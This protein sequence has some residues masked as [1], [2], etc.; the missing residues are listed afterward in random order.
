MVANFVSD[1]AQDATVRSL[2]EVSV[3]ETMAVYLSLLEKAPD[4]ADVAALALREHGRAGRLEASHIQMLGAFV[5]GAPNPLCA[6]HL[7]KALAAMGREATEASEPLIAKMRPMMITDDVEYW[8]FD[9]CVWAL[10]YLGG[11][12]VAPFLD[13][14]ERETPSRAV[15]SNSIYRGVMPKDAREAA[16]AKALAAARD[17]NSKPNPG[18]WRTQQ[19]KIGRPTTTQPKM[20]GRAWD[21]RSADNGARKMR[22][23]SGK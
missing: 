20:A 6:G 21:V 8:S 9:G 23:A 7:A 3:E 16:Y 11:K 2:V 18:V 22:K 12:L 17:L 15:R 5:A 19:M 1:P 10:G 13:E 14:L 4:K